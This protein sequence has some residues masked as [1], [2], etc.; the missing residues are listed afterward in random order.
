VSNCGKPVG[1]DIQF[2]C[3]RQGRGENSWFRL[4]LVGWDPV[5]DS[6]EEVAKAGESRMNLQNYAVIQV[7][8]LECTSVEAGRM[9]DVL[10]S[11]FVVYMDGQR[12]RTRT[13]VVLLR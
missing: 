9:K 12:R 4:I 11:S 8:K 5:K 3:K 6:R 2:G 10:E 7:K 1:F 13:Q